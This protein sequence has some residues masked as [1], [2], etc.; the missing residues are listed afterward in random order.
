LF[1]GVVI[2]DVGFV[3][4]TVTFTTDD[5]IVFPARSVAFDW[6]VW[7]LVDKLVAEYV[8]AAAEPLVATNAPLSTEI[9]VFCKLVSADVP[10]KFTVVDDE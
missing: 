5:R 3:V 1:A 7:E 8:Q 10:V 6:N 9:S 4:S 2:E